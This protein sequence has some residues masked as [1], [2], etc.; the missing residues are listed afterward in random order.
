[1]VTGQSCR[2][3]K[4]VLL[5]IHVFPNYLPG[6]RAQEH[7]PFWLTLSLPPGKPTLVRMLAKITVPQMTADEL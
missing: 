7:S 3:Q 5:N 2:S 1:M 6:R 4:V